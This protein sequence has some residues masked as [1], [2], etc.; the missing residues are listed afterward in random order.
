VSAPARS[1]PTQAPS[2]AFFIFSDKGIPKLMQSRITAGEI[3]VSLN[4][5]DLTLRTTP[6]AGLQI[7]RQY[8]GLAKARQQLVDEN[9]DAIVFILRLGSGM[10]DRDA[11]DLG[12]R[13]Y[14][15]GITAD[16][17][18]PL[19]KYVAMLGNGGKPL[20]EDETGGDGTSDAAQP[21]TDA[22][23]NAGNY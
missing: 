9:I 13:V 14:R 10:S 6:R 18:V 21:R 16:L 15:N 12:D 4:G 17:L 5:N 8:G 7:S 23:G 22:E 19:I 1:N 2:G 3:T 11:K 20:D